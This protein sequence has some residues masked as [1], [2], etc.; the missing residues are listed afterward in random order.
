[1]TDIE[2]LLL[3]RERSESGTARSLRESAHLSR[4]D[5]ARACGVT[6]GAVLMWEAGRRRP[7]GDAGIAFGRL[8]A[9]LEGR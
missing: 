3:A 6:S 2:L 7:S 8:L 5:V 1:M 9:N 4:G